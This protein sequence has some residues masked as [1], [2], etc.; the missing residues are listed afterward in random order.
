M[1]ATSHD[2]LDTK[3]KADMQTTRE[4]LDQAE[5]DLAVAGDKQRPVEERTALVERYIRLM[6]TRPI[7]LAGFSMEG[8]TH[9]MSA[10]VDV[11]YPTEWG[12]I[13][14]RSKDISRKWLELFQ[15]HETPLS[16]DLGEL[17]GWVGLKLARLNL[18]AVDMSN[19]A[20][21]RDTNFIAPDGSLRPERPSAEEVLG[22]RKYA[23]LLTVKRYGTWAAVQQYNSGSD[24]LAVTQEMIDQGYLSSSE[25][26][27]LLQ[28]TEKTFSEMAL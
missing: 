19:G 10:G 23:I 17:Q 4:A 9:L 2:D 11:K 7:H 24:L 28:V 15:T 27:E 5:H 26:G 14:R 8:P 12:D 1:E 20:P 13:L 3:M 16:P 22:K 21:G 6:K 25:D 18:P